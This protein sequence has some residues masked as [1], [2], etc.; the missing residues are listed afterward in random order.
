[1]KKIKVVL[2]IVVIAFIGLVFFQNKDFFLAGRGLTLNLYFANAYHSPE[3]PLAVWFLA[4]FF[5]GL[6]VAYFFGLMEKFKANKLIKSLRVKTTTQTEL[7]SKLRHELESHAGLGPE[8]ARAPSADN[9]NT[10]HEPATMQTT[11][12][13]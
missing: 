11:S 8:A 4:T 13:D 7:I 3:L 12:D 6:L 10:V 1:M 9:A 2:W 5:I